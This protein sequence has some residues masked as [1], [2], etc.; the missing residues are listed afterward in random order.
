MEEEPIAPLCPAQLRPMGQAP[1][2]AAIVW[3]HAGN[4]IHFKEFGSFMQS[5]SLLT[6]PY[7]NAHTP[8]CQE[9]AVTSP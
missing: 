1:N 8:G 3:S 5:K 6:L 7:F 2:P 4:Q 9:K